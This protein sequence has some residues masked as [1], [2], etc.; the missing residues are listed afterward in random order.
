MSP[1]LSNDELVVLNEAFRAVCTAFGLGARADGNER[2]ER[3]PKTIISL[4]NAGEHDPA[5]I[6]RRAFE[7]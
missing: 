7:T 1:S 3:L 6:A 4:A 2:R 5:A